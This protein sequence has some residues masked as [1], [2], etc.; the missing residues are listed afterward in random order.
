MR[1]NAHLTFRGECEA[2][3]RFYEQTLGGQLITM[4][5]YGDSPMAASVPPD[6]R[7]KI[8]HATLSL[9]DGSLL[10]GA[11]VE[12][13]HYQQPRGFYVLLTVATANDA[14]RVFSALA[15]G[16]R[17]EMALQKT[18]WSEAFG[19]VVDRFGVPWEVGCERM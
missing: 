11:D 7:D 16:G 3:F 17:V 1:A 15:E 9:G 8:V 4:L 10:L 18:F 6:W 12:P 14:Q 19:V 5:R 13:E 2:A